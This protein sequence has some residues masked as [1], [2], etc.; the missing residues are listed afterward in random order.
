MKAS[1]IDY[2]KVHDRFP[3]GGNVKL[4]DWRDIGSGGEVPILLSLILACFKEDY[5]EELESEFQVLFPW[6]TLS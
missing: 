2:S 6:G 4:L 1:T 5:R 3:F